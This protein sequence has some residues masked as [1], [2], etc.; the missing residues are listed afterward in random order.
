M[1]KINIR[2]LLSQVRNTGVKKRLILDTDTYNE[3]DDQFALAW[4]LLCDQSKVELLSVNAAP[5]HNNRSNGPEDGMEK[6]Y[7]EILNIM[8]LTGQNRPVYKG[9]REYTKSVSVPVE[10]EA[11]DNIIR[12]AR[13][14]EDILYVAA[15]GAI[16]NVASAIVK[17]PDIIDKIAIIWLGGTAHNWPHTK[18]FNLIQDIFAAK[19]IFDSGVYLLQLPCAGVVDH[20]ATTIPELKYYLGGKNPLCDYLVNIVDGYGGG[21]CWSKVIWDI[22]AI[23]ALICPNSED[24]V[25]KPAPI[26]TLDGTYSFDDG[27]HD[28]LYCRALNRDMIFA[29]LFTLLAGI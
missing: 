9:S 29:H 1:A 22:S 16:T 3:V 2:E 7:S 19:V 28:M 21:M 13:E 25:I 24:I 26:V 14:S 6:S 4:A 15:I 17:A 11:A 8:K 20:L 12:T 5:F 23:A 27:R 18:E 10:S